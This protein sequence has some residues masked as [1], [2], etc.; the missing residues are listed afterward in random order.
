MFSFCGKY[1]I[2]NGSKFWISNGGLVDIFI[3]FVKILVI[4]LV[5]GVVKEKIIVFVVERGFGG[6]I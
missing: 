6:V 2:F 4:D 5:M 3:V 1:Y